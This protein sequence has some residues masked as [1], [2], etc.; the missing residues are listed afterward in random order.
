MPKT[1]QVQEN[2]SLA[3]F[4]TLKIGGKARLFVKAESEKQV[5]SAVKFAVE[6]DFDLF[7]LGGGSNVLISD[8]GFDGLVL[9]IALRGIEFG[10]EKDG[11]VK[12]KACAGEDWD[13]FVKVCVEKNLQG[14]ECLS[15]IPGLIGGTP[16]QNVGAYGQEVA[17]TIST[18]R[19]FD[20][21]SG[22]LLELSNADCKFSYRTSIFNSTEKNR[23]IVLAVTFLLRQNGEPKI[24]YKDLREHFS[25]KTPDLSEA[26]IAV[27]QIRSAKSMVIDENDVNSRSA[28]SFFKNPIVSKEKLEKIKESFNVEV[29][30]FSVDAD[31][32]KIPAAWL[33]ENA[34]F[35]KGFR[36]GNIGLSEN[37]PLAIVNFGEAGSEDVIELKNLIQQNVREKFGIALIPEPVFVGFATN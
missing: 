11:I 16:V 34:G 10:T 31:N 14:L 37:H 27:L 8:K 9:Q 17:E 19:V 26:R 25:G 28:G 18:V 32:V 6:N 5:V 7:V 24:V 33:I 20:R 1:I 23:F 30:F 36:K 2:I 22:E 35:Y 12:V 15:G 13:E 3:P 4:T 21:K 29:P